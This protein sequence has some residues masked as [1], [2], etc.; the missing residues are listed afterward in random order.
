MGVSSLSGEEAR[1]QG[2]LG[3]QGAVEAQRLQS[4]PRLVP[5]IMASLLTA[6]IRDCEEKHVTNLYFKH[7]GSLNWQLK[8]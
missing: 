6:G 3:S 4:G 1:G 7:N 2:V 8:Q 5:E